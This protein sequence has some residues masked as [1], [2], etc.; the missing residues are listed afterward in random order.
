MGARGVD[1]ETDPLA[2][3][4]ARKEFDEGDAECGVNDVRFFVLHIRSMAV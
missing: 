2:A 3:G 1:R 4:K